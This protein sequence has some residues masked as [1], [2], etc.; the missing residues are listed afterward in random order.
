M[1]ACCSIPLAAQMKNLVQPELRGLTSNHRFM[2]L[3]EIKRYT[4]TAR[5]WIAGLG[6]SA[7][8]SGL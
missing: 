1:M 8:E 2:K 3:K 4:P 6:N 7:P 5:R